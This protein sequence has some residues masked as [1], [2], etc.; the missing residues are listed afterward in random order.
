[1]VSRPGLPFNFSVFITVAIPPTPPAQLPASPRHVLVTGG[2]GY[3]GCVLVPALLARGYRVTVLDWFLF[4]PPPPAARNLRCIRADLRDHDVVG[5]ALEGVDAVIHLA[6]LSNDPSSDIDPVATREI[7]LDAAC[8]LADAALRAGVPRFVNTSSASVYGI[9]AEERV[10]ESLPLRPLTLYARYKAES[11]AYALGLNRPGFTVVSVRPATLSGYSPR[12]RLDLTVNILASQA[13][14]H[15]E[16]RVFGGEQ[17]RPNLS[18]HDVV[19]MYLALLEHHPDLV[20]G[21]TFNVCEGNYRVIEIAER[22]RDA[23]GLD[24]PIERVETNDHRSYRLCADLARDVL[25]FVPAHGLAHSI[26]EV[27]G[28]LA[29]GRVPAPASAVHRNVDFLR[30]RDLHDRAALL[31]DGLGAAA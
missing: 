14:C 12:L 19:R 11:E 24:V 9:A 17:Y 16:I 8:R 20:A 30:G 22:V 6:A 15:G 29:D 31:R 4:S 18:V 5:S 25:G 1:M 13:V 10:T 27:A 7:N 3:V 26:R 28:A 2:A 21:R 23:L